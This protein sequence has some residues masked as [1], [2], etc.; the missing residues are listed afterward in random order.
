MAIPE[1][2]RQSVRERANNCCE[3]CRLPEA[4]G[5]LPFHVDHII[6][7]KHGGTD[8][9]DNLC[10]ACFK[11]NAHKSHD[12]AGFDPETGEL[13]RLYHPRKQTWKDHFVLR[14]DMYIQ[15]LTPMERVS[16]CGA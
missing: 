4:A 8:D 1:R 7:V 3:Y 9:L 11:C 14:D 10:L 16:S 6:P 12:L 2:F 15:G 5:T 13:T